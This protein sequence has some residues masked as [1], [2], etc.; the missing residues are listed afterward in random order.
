MTPTPASLR[1]MS[2][3]A[4]LP[5][6]VYQSH[7]QIRRIIDAADNMHARVPMTFV[8]FD[9]P[10]PVGAPTLFRYR[11]VAADGR[12]W[13]QMINIVGQDQDPPMDFAITMMWRES[14]F[15]LQR[16]LR[17]ELVRARIQLGLARMRYDF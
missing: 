15:E 6:S 2:T 1:G 5:A 8:L 11:M 13:L 10:D 12:S 14:E 9:C 17:R 3:I 16:P 4:L 7:P